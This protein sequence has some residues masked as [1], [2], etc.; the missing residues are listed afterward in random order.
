MLKAFEE[1]I[2]KFYTKEAGVTTS[3]KSNT[4]DA[5]DHKL[6]IDNDTGLK[7]SC[8]NDRQ[9]NIPCENSEITLEKPQVLDIPHTNSCHGTYGLNISPG[10]GETCKYDHPK[11]AKNSSENVRSEQEAV[12]GSTSVYCGIKR[13]LD[14]SEDN[15]EVSYEER[16]KKARF[17]TEK[18]SLEENNE[19]EITKKGRLFSLDDSLDDLLLTNEKMHNHSRNITDKENIDI[20]TDNVDVN[21]DYNN[22][23]SFG[24]KDLSVELPERSSQGHSFDCLNDSNFVTSTRAENDSVKG[25]CS[26]KTIS[27]STSVIGESGVNHLNPDSAFKLFDDSDEDMMMLDIDTPVKNQENGNSIL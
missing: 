18:K 13:A 27:R 10:Y 6:L 1:E 20:T 4:K 5:L 19:L 23:T 17:D 16:V 21:E 22:L 8:H 3:S 14:I 11:H 24:S 12:E 7:Q 15:T 9:K 2:E 26:T 25:H